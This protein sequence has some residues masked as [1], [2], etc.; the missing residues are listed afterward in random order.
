MGF[1]TFPG[2]QIT[3]GSYTGDDSVNRALPHGLGTTPKI[4]AIYGGMYSAS[5]NFF[6]AIHPSY[7]YILYVSGATQGR[8]AVTALDGTNFYVGNASNYGQSAN[9]DTLLYYWVAFG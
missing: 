6:Y 5:N 8:Y 7:N 1:H 9:A 4:V 3:S 2:V